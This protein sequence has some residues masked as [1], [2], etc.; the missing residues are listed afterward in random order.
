[1]AGPLLIT[2]FVA[3][4]GIRALYWIAV[5]GLLATVVLLKVVPRPGG[6]QRKA[7]GFDY[8]IAKI[9]RPILP[10]FLY[11]LTVSV[12]AMNLYSFVPIYL[13]QHG[14]S[15]G[16][17]GAAL[18]FLSLGCAIGPLAGSYAGRRV[19]R[20]RVPAAA[21]VLSTSCLL[22]FLGAPAAGYVQTA[23]LLFLGFFLMLP[24]SILIAMAQERAPQYVGTVSSFLGGFV[25]GCGGVLVIAFARLAELTS[26]ERLLGGLVLF[27]L[28]G[29]AVALTAPALR[30]PVSERGPGLLTAERPGPRAQRRRL[31]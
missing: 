2:G 8:P 13:K 24:F 12:T 4:A 10:F 6:S 31:Q 14:A 9:I 5:P 17:I 19:G 26:V 20:A 18:S 16:L 1:V 7:K 21:A 23:A 27:P 11:A 15:G 3:S 25:W 29:L 22:L 28:L 30:A